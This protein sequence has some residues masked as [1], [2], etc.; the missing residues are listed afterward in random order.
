M[1]RSGVSSPTAL[2]AQLG[3]SVRTLRNW[4]RQLDDAH[5]DASALSNSA[6]SSELLSDGDAGTDALL[7]RVATTELRSDDAEEADASPEQ[8][9]PAEVIS[10]RNGV[11]EEWSDELEV[12]EGQERDLSG[13]STATALDVLTRRWWVVLSLT[14]LAILAAWV[15]SSSVPPR[16]Q[17]TATVLAHPAAAVTRASDY[18]TDLSLL[19]YGSLEQT[20]V[21]LA[22]SSKLIDE[23][24]SGM[25]FGRSSRERFAWCTEAAVI[26]CPPR[27]R[28]LISP[29]QDRSPC[30]A[31]ETR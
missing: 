21:A 25:G 23:A 8:E 26:R 31:P 17:A 4:Q 16:Y 15:Y 7:D 6:T 2:A 20:F 3:C 14:S 13:A 27:C 29:G 5:G 18:S 30:S 28:G 24:A 11:V 9:A 10:A 19:S 22:R 12:P 1:L